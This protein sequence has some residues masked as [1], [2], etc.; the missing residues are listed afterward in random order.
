M[1]AAVIRGF[2][3]VEVFS[4]EDV[5]PPEPTAEHVVVKVLACGLNRYD[6][7]LR[8]G[9]IR[10]DVPMPHVMGADVAGEIAAVGPGVMGW[11]EGQRVIVAPGF[12]L[13]RREWGFEPAN[14]ADSFTVTGTLQWGGYAQYMRVPACF[15]FADET[16]LPP[17]QV[18]CAPLVTVTAVHAVKTL[19]EVGPGRKVLVQAGAS[20][21]GSMCIQM[22]KHLG[23]S[24]ATTVGSAEKFDLVRQCGAELVINYR[25]DDF[26]RRVLEWTGGR[27]VDTVIDN[28]G[29][30]VFEGNLKALR[31][32][33]IFVNF[34]LVGGIK[35]T[36]NFAHLLFGQYHLR[37][38]M[39]GSMAE[40]RYGLGLLKEGAIRPV[41]DR[42]FPLSAASA[43]HA[44]LESRD[45][46]GKTV[47]LPWVE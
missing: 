37:G 4:Y 34:G 39:M 25:E 19:G 35:G 28:V 30:S 15:L 40:L 22:A 12:P 7:Y 27:G 18:A 26:A 31:R 46:R 47:L 20:G 16:D 11:R 2:G 29:G 36:L 33:G 44:H 45:V 32:G 5:P 24:V 23:G 41:P 14:M 42:T 17:E 10:R 43:A 9:G 1:K 8:M 38:S 3:G 6:S 21:S 13:D